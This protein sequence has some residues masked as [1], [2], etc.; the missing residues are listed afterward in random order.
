MMRVLATDDSARRRL[1]SLAALSLVVWVATISTLLSDVSF[2]ANSCYN[3][4]P[5]VRVR[6]DE[7]QDVDVPF[8]RVA[9]LMSWPNSG[10]SYT[11]RIV[12]EISN[13][14]TATNYGHEHLINDSSILVHQDWT[15][16]PFRANVF[17]ELPK[18]FILT[19][20]HCGSR[21]VHC[22]PDGYLE[23]PRTFQRSCQSG[24]RYFNSTWSKEGIYKQNIVSRA[25]HLI[26]N[27]LDNVVSRF[28]LS[29]RHSSDKGFDNN[30]TGF[31]EWCA[32][33]DTAYEMHE[34]HTPW[35]DPPLLLLWKD[36]PCH[37]EFFKYI[38]WHN[39]AWTTA[40]NMNIPMHL[41]R[42]EDYDLDWK[43]TVDALLSFLQ[44][45]AA[46]WEGVTPY[47]IQ[48]YH[49]FYS[50]QQKEAIEALLHN[51]ASAPIWEIV[52]KYFHDESI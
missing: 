39:L 50:T 47:E 38:Q 3:Q 37:A 31:Q 52:S 20:T 34:S 25:V 19:K 43:G 9:W 36:V 14:S 13:L 7:L 45:P 12:R 33:M 4:E 21:C 27:P 48:T 18:H 29:R 6:H 30:A 11:L 8:P 10:T 2:P 32:K 23:T 41:L 35:L 42:Y 15:R 40:Q 44:I 5:V 16:G 24:R 28:H 17:Q 26:R 46:S 22:G 49:S 1:P 51:V